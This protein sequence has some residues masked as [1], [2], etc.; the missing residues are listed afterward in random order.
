M[1]VE[2][3]SPDDEMLDAEI[4]KRVSIVLSEA[5]HK[6]YFSVVSATVRIN[7]KRTY[8]LD[9]LRREP[10]Q[11]KE[12]IS[13]GV[14]VEQMLLDTLESR[15]RRS[16]RQKAARRLSAQAKREATSK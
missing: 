13:V 11:G 16:D 1:T 14:L 4:L 10:E 5:Q 9:E 2:L 3:K 8:V 15:K 12:G 6:G 7:D